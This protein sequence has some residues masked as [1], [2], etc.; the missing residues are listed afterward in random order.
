MVIKVVMD[1]SMALSV[2][3][4]QI[5][6]DPRLLECVK[7]FDIKGLQ[8]MFS[9]GKVKSTDLV[10]DPQRSRGLRPESLLEV[11][12]CTMRI[13]KDPLIHT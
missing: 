5:N 1:S 8:D 6:P 2:N 12:P 9:Q 11:Y 7:A 3:R 4:A 13:F 10:L